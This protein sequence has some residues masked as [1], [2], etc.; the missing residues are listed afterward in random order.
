M[1]NVEQYVNIKAL[2]QEGHSIRAISRITGHSRNTIRKVLR[3]QH[4]MKIK[5]IDRR[6]ILDP[7]KEYLRNR[8][9]KTGLSAIRLL[10]EIQPMGYSGSI[11]TLRRYVKTLK[12]DITRAKRLTVRFETPPGKQAQADWAYCGKFD[13]PSGKKLSVYFFVMVLS[14]SRMMFI[15]FTTSMKM[16]YLL[17][18]HQ[19]AFD[20]FSGVTETILYDNMKQVKISRSKYNETLLDFANHY[21]FIPKTH[22][23]YRPRTKGKVERAVDYVK[24][25]FLTGRTFEGLDDLNAQGQHWLNHIA[26]IRVHGTTGKRPVDLFEKEK[27]NDV[28]VLPAYHLASPVLRVANYESMVQFNNSRYSVPPEYAGKTLEVFSRDGNVLVQ[29]GDTIIAEH[30]CAAKPGQCVVDKEHIQELWKITEKQI[31]PPVNARFRINFTQSV[32][33]TPLTTFQEVVA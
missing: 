23:P 17:E 1:I 3:N 8:F 10:E 24:D 13:T 29:T 20:A 33:Q 9:E 6:S 28:S 22:Q 32:Q 30:S 4:D 2:K 16:P 25:N 26:N 19:K 27:L 21:G 18:C 15:Q 31:R 14:Y 5:S 12:Q 7:F 11:N